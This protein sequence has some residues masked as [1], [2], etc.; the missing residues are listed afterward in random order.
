MMRPARSFCAA[1]LAVVGIEARAADYV[2]DF[3][4]AS[5][6]L[7]GNSATAIAQTP[8][9]YL[10]VGGYDGLARFDGVRFV[11][12]DSSNTREL[13][14]TRVER[15]VTD[16]AGTLW[17]NTY[18]GSLT[19][20]RAGV[21][22]AEWT[23]RERVESGVWLAA[24]TDREQVFV[25]QSG[26]VLRRTL[27]KDRAGPW[28]TIRPDGVVFSPTFC[29]TRSGALWIRSTDERL[30]RIVEG[31]AEEVESA[32]RGRLIRHLTTDLED[33]VVIGTD[34]GIWRW[35]G[36]GFTPMP[37]REGPAR[38]D[39]S[40]LHF[41]EEDSL[42]AI[43][44][45][46]LLQARDGR[47]IR[48]LGSS[49]YLTEDVLQPRLPIA[50]RRGG[51]WFAHGGRG[52]LHVDGQGASRLFGAAQGF[53]SER[54]VSMFK[55]REANLW[56]SVD[57]GGLARIRERRFD[58]IPVPERGSSYATVSVA[59]GPKGSVW[60]GSAG[61]GLA[62]WREGALRLFSL[63]GPATRPVV[64]SLFP[65]GDRLWMSAD[66]EDLWV[67]ENGLP[68]P[69]SPAVHGIKVLLVDRGGRLWMGRRDG[70]SRR[71]EGRVEHFGP[72]EGM[73]VTEVRALAEDENGAIWIGGGDGTLHRY[74]DG[75]FERIPV[76]EE[77]T[78]HQIWSL[79]SQAGGVLWIGT[80]QGGLLRLDHGRVFRYTTREGL[81]SSVVCQIVDDDQ[82]HLWVG[83]REGLLRVT[84]KSLTDVAARTASSLVSSTYGRADGVPPLEC[85]GYQPGSWRGR[86]GRL[87]FATTGGAVSVDPAALRNNETPPAAVVEEVWIDRVRGEEQAA[88][89]AVVV[90]AGGREVEFRYTGLSLSAPE[91]V[92]FRYRL[93]GLEP[94]WSPPTDRRTAQYSYLPPGDYRF[95]VMARNSDGVWSAREASLPLKVLPH[96]W[97]TVGFRSLLALFS[98][99]G[100]AAIARHLSTRTL[101]R[102][103]ARLE[104][105]HAVERD[106]TRIAKD[107]HDDLGAGLTQISLLSELLR[108]DNPQ[109]AKAHAEQIGETAVELTRAMDE[110]V[111]AVNPRE[112]TLDSLWDYITHFAQEYLATAGIACRLEAPETIPAIPL[113]AEARHNLFLAVKEA[114]NNVVKHAGA[115]EVRLR[116]AVSS[117]EFEIEVQD[118]GRGRGAAPARTPL[119]VQGGRGLRNIDERML[120]IGARF[121]IS[122]GALG[123]TRVR[124][125]LTRP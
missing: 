91:A 1:L 32:P 103:L 55:D 100:A 81:A 120:S 106:R 88:S 26:S 122:N 53:A 54:V 49:R 29:T 2:I 78:S 102:N 34:N 77:G 30:W 43:V 8:E 36:T 123:G 37:L 9:G 70:L 74:F 80:Y 108:D 125:T 69:T 68:R 40:F 5:R 73:P 86:D 51:L 22:K 82:G 60:I 65:D 109:E 28:E 52:L 23:A 45:E 96:F 75:R 19:S 16:S 124:L 48:D 71:T 50:D 58:L 21:F 4:D 27:A 110:I 84:Q 118:D 79:R 10:W 64:L 57:R 87:W 62:R 113:R 119:R 24:S 38:L 13:G 20:W 25:L 18:D 89:G 107:I 111:W 33:R 99:A 95:E 105:Q 92:R 76:G 39:V 11:R 41:A 117:A 67:L 112:D 115:S 83:S 63:P 116:L 85:S 12:F 17:I 42:W 3:W 44:N 104:R 56:V 7:P 72:A 47:W 98:L 97:E 31:R 90:P 66:H 35:T 6:G 121:Q 59:E 93:T 15:L 61:A 94:D 101:R 14:H 114:L 46:R